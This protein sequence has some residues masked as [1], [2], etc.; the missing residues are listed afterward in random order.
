MLIHRDNNLIQGQFQFVRDGLNDTEVDLMWSQPV[1]I[2]LLHAIRRGCL[3]NDARKGGDR[4]L[5]QL[6]PLHLQI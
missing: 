3:F 6:G 1:D 5:E 2:Q 4:Y